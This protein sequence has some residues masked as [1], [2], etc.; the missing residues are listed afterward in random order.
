[1][2]MHKKLLSA[3]VAAMVAA[4]G[5]GLSATA[6]AADV[7]GSVAIANMYLWRGQDLGNGAGAIS[8]DLSVSESGFHTGVWGSSGDSTH[9]TEYDLYAGYGG[10]SGDFKYDLTFWTYAYPSNGGN[11]DTDNVG[12]LSE[13][14]LTLG[15]GPVS[16]SY[17]DNIANASDNNDYA[18]YTLTG[19]YQKFAVTLGYAAY[20]ADVYDVNHVRIGETE[21]LDYTHLDVTYAYN[22]NLSFTVSQVVDESDDALVDNDPKFVVKYVLPLK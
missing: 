11:D 17:Y 9:G 22:D 19:T 7:A 18:Y 5:M 16:F 4:A 15:Y 10:A 20:K 6:S 12:D 3:G 21:K 13:A 8:G 14:V 2:K 1:M